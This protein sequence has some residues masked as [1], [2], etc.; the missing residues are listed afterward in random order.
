MLLVPLFPPAFTPHTPL[1]ANHTELGTGELQILMADESV[2]AVW[3]N[4]AAARDELLSATPAPIVRRGVALGRQLLDPL[5]L[6][7]SLCGGGGK[8]VLALQLH[9]LQSQVWV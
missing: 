6:L 4:S 3:E 1:P 8:E 5:A 9:P 7:A 2:A